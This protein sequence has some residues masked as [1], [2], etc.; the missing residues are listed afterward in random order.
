MKTN[1]LRLLFWNTAL[2]H[3]LGQTHDWVVVYFDD[4]VISGQCTVVTE[5]RG[6]LRGLR[7]VRGRERECRD[8]Y[9]A[10]PAQTKSA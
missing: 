9:A 1:F 7:V 4:G 10:E 2:A 3:R 5:T 8:A 6:D